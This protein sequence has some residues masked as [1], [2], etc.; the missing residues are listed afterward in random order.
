VSVQVHPR[1]I[2]RDA[3]RGSSV[4]SAIPPVVCKGWIPASVPEIWRSPASMN[5]VMGSEPI[6]LSSRE[7]ASRSFPGVRVIADAAWVFVMRLFWGGNAALAR[8]RQPS[9]PSR[10]PRATNSARTRRA[11]PQLL[12]PHTRDSNQ[13]GRRISTRSLSSRTQLR[14]ERFHE[15]SSRDLVTP[16]DQGAARPS[17]QQPRSPGTR[18]SRC[19]RLPRSEL[20]VACR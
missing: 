4:R 5:W 1:S 2:D 14:G 19:R 13:G 9:T 10:A 12:P 11:S 3:R 18:R 7:S 16:P 20:S 6:P 17:D 15:V 8:R